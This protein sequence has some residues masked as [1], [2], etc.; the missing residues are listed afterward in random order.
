MKNIRIACISDTHEQ[1]SSIDIP[2]CDILVHAGDITS[3]GDYDKLVQFDAWG[4][5]LGLPRERMICIAGNHDKT[6]EGDAETAEAI[7]THWTYLQDAA[8]EVCG[9]K[10]W[11]TPWSL[12]FFRERW[13]FN[14]RRGEPARACWDMIPAGTDVLVVHGPPRHYGDKLEGGEHVGCPDLADVLSGIRP[15]LTVCGH[16]HSDPGIFAAPWGTV[17]NASSLDENY[18]PAGSPVVINLRVPGLEE[19]QKW[20]DG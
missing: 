15:R 10:F 2:P 12:E 5:S 1:E 4:G 14:V 18:S 7:L 3:E 20:R 11:G 16:V 6:L 8:H 9:L 13:V 17:V 19:L